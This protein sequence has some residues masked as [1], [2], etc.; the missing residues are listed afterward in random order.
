MLE[1]TTGGAD[2]E[3]AIGLITASGEVQVPPTGTKSMG[4]YNAVNNPPA[5]YRDKPHEKAVHFDDAVAYEE[6]TSDEEDDGDFNPNE[7]GAVS[8]MSMDDDESPD[9]STSDSG[10]DSDSDSGSNT[11]SSSSSS[12]EESDS[13]QSSGP[14]VVPSKPVPAHNVPP[15][16]GKK[17]TKA[18][19]QR[20]IV[21][22]K[23]RQLVESGLLPAQSTLKDTRQHLRQDE[24]ELD[25]DTA[26]PVAQAQKSSH[27]RK[28]GGTELM[29]EERLQAGDELEERRKTL[30]AALNL[31]ATSSETTKVGGLG[32]S[33]EVMKQPPVQEPVQEPARKRLRPDTSAITRILSHQT[34]V[35]IRIVQPDSSLT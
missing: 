21:A 19:N 5:Q 34:R 25:A 1:E 27:K 6:S 12:G 8:D 33:A 30:L 15:Y 10:S 7:A 24:T 18:R 29:P 22:K 26:K 28:R 3:G 17:A 35:S 13:S 32:E 31:D 20:R 23:R 11:D 2:E 4:R 9:D 16:A 14:E